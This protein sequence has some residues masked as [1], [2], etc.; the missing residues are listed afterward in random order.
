[1]QKTTAPGK[2]KPVKP[3]FFL[4]NLDTW[5]LQH[6]QAFIFSLGQLCRNPVASFLTIAVIGISLALPAG[7]HIILNNARQLTAGWEGTVQITAFLKME[8][9]N[10]TAGSTG[11]IKCN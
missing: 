3:P 2:N 6:M 7:F 11:L 4:V 5:V 9:D 8:V 1:M 10:D